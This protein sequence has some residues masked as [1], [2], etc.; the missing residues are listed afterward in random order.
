MTFAGNPEEGGRIYTAC[1]QITALTT[2]ATE[3]VTLLPS[4]MTRVEIVSLHLGQLLSTALVTPMLVELWRGV[5][6]GS[7]GAAITPVNRN[8]WTAAPASTCTVTGNSTTPN[9]TASASL[10]HRE[11]FEQDSGKFTWEPCHRPN[12]EI[13]QRF[14]AR[15][16]PMTTAALNGL[17]MTLT[18][19]EGGKIPGQ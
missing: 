9:S 13:S 17:T 19:R 7:T 3:V 14:S 15:V 16:T 8:G 10:L 12:L 5:G 2:A 11:T 6:T 18:F 1:N 4:S